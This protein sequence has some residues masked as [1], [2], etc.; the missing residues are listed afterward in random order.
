M[1]YIAYLALFVVLFALF[2]YWSFPYDSLKD[3]ILGDVERQLGGGLQ[4]SAKTLEPHWFSGVEIEDLVI[5]GPGERGL[6]K[7]VSF[8]RV[9]ARASLIPLIFG[10]VRVKFSIDLGNGE[11]SGR[12]NVGD[13]TVALKVEVDD[14]NLA[15]F[16]FLQERTGLRITS[17]IDGDADFSINQAQPIRSTG[18][19][20]VAFKN[21]MIGSS[22]LNAG[23]LVLE[24]PDLVIA[25]GKGSQLRM[26]M[27]RGTLTMENFAFTGGDLGIDLKG[28]IF[29][30]RRVNNYRL[31]IRGKFSVSQKL[32]DAF[33]FLFIVDSQKQEDGS[34][35][36]SITGRLSRPSIKIGTF[37]VPL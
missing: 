6:T 30:S 17:R 22:Q 26:S 7:L 19:V 28:K 36:L 12:A 2:L 10:S 37:T 11:I 15:D 16:P 33:P 25:K 8:K 1:K 32:N 18:K 20:N 35:P 27:G 24:V 4:V 3:R 34:Y 14:L 29:L 9:K 5:E 23:E 31:N 21:L 13:E